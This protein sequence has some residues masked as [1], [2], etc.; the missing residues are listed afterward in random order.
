MQIVNSP[1]QSSLFTTA[2]IVGNASGN[3][4][5]ASNGVTFIFNGTQ[6]PNSKDNTHDSLI[7]IS[8]GPFVGSKAPFVV[9]GFLDEPE[10]TLLTQQLV[11]VAERLELSL[12]CWPSTGLVTTVLMTQLSEQLHVKRMSLL[13]SLSRDLMMSKQEHLPCMVHNWLGERRIALTLQTHNLNWKELYLTEPARNNTTAIDPSSTSSIDSQCPFTQLIEIGKHVDCSEQQRQQSISNLEE[14]SSS[15]ISCWL[16]HSTQEKLLTCE[17]LFF[18]QTPELTP[19][20]WYLLNNLASQYLDGIRQR[21]AY[22]QQ[23]LI[24]ES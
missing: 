18:N 10:E 24:S 8:N 17:N 7:N 11:E 21:L 22:C 15:H 20:Y 4:D 14:M 13:P 12:N 2:T 6:S 5:I 16:N 1:C 23:M 3:W 9:T 19:T